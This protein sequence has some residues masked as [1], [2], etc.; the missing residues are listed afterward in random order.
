RQ[1]A[2]HGDRRQKQQT[3]DGRDWRPALS[4][5]RVSFLAALGM[6]PIVAT[7]AG[8]SIVPDGRTD[9]TVAVDGT[10]INVRTR[11]KRGGNAFNS[12]HDF[13]VKRNNT[14]NLHLPDGSKNLINLVHDSRAVINGT[15]NS[16]KNGRIGGHI[17]FADPHGVVVGANGVVNVGSLLMTT[18]TSEFMDR[19]IAKDGTIDD[20]A[21][22]RLLRGQAPISD[23]GLVQVDGEINAA[24]AIEISGMDVAVTG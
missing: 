11:T 7:S 15:L 5:F 3:A 20:A 10:T 14:A 6:A 16:I 9:T 12:F 17:V 21:V 8:N 2:A 13:N 22:A 4:H 18:P 23:D 19:V 1:S 24:G